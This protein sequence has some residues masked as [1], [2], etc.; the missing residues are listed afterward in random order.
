MYAKIESGQTP[1]HHQQSGVPVPHGMQVVPLAPRG[2]NTL[3]VV[4]K[5]TQ[6]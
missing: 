2:C 5:T 1:H 3:G 4:T 6:M